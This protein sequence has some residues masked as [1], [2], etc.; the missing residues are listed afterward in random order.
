MQ[1][2]IRNRRAEARQHPNRGTVDHAH[3][4]AQRFLDAVSNACFGVAIELRGQ[5]RGLGAFAI[6][7]PQIGNAEPRQRKRNRLADAARAD[8]GHRAMRAGGD[9]VGDGSR[10]TGR[11]GVVADQPAV[12]D[13]DGI[14]RA[15]QCRARR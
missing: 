12:A 1:Q 9:E 6:E 10:K 8:Q 15:D 14:D 3:D 2:V 5:F 7:D 13:D 11:I 4:P